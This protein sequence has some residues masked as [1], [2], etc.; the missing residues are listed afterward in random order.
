M[1]VGILTYHAACNFGAFLQL[2]STFEYIRNR[3][4]IPIVI[5][6]VPLDFEKDYQV[7]SKREV[8][9]LYANYRE[10]YFTLTRLCRTSKEVAEVIKEENIDAIIV[11]SDAVIQHHPFRERFHFPC[12]RIFYIYNPTSDRMFP[13]AFWGE[14]L[15]YGISVPVAMMSGASVDSKYF[16]I[17]GNKKKKMKDSILQFSYF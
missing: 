7:R 3:G 2:L 11:G 8:R 13:N 5:N 16:Y 15:R 14:F 4:D 17:K 10:L 6:W 1:K 12:R 9:E